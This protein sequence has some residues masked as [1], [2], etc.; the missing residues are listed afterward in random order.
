MTSPSNN[1]ATDPESELTK[2]TFSLTRC[3]GLVLVVASLALAGCDDGGDSSSDDI[4]IGEEGEVGEEG[5]R[6]GIVGD[7][8]D[9]GDVGDEGPVAGGP[10]DTG[11]VGDQGPIV[12]GP[13]DTGDVGDQGPVV[14][15]PG[16]TGDVGDQGPIVG[17]PG[18]TGDVG[19]QGP[20]VGGPGDTGDVGDEGP[21]GG[22][23]C[24]GD[25]C[26]D[27]QPPSLR[28]SVSSTSLEHYQELQ[29]E[30]DA[31]DP[32]GAIKAVRFML[33][34]YELQTLT[35][36]PYTLS[37]VPPVGEQVFSAVA[38]DNDGAASDE[39]IV[40][41]SV[42]PLVWTAESG[43]NSVRSLNVNTQHPYLFVDSELITQILSAGKAD[44]RS[45]LNSLMS[46]Y[47]TPSGSDTYAWVE[48]KVINF[49]SMDQFI[50]ASMYYGMEANFNPSDNAKNHAH[51]FALALLEYPAIWGN[52]GP[53]R[54]RL[55]ALGA[56]Y[57]WAYDELS[58]S[59]RRLLRAA[60]LEQADYVDEKWSY[61][62]SPAYSGGHSRKA[63][64]TA[65]AA[66]LAIFHDISQD[67]SDM[68]SRY[69]ELLA[70]VVNN[71]E[72]GYNPFLAWTSRNGGSEKAYSYSTSYG[73]LDVNLMWEYATNE[74]SWLTEVDADQFYRYLYGIRNLNG[75][76]AY[77]SGGYYNFPYHGDSWGTDY[78]RQFQ[79]FPMLV[80]STFFDNGYAQWLYDSLSQTNFYWHILYA[81]PSPISP[82]NPS[83]L[84]LSRHFYNSGQVV[85][86]DS[87]DPAKNTLTI[88]KST[89]FNSINHHH[90]DSNAFT[91]Y[92]KGPLAI[93]SGG[94]NIMGA[95]ASKHWWNYYTRSIA[96][97]TILVY[98]KTEDFRSVPTHGQRSNDGG[99]RYRQWDI[100]PTLEDVKAGG[101]SH[102][103]GIV[104]YEEQGD[105]TYTMGDATEAYSSHKLALYQR[106][107][108]SLRNHSGSHPVVLVYDVVEST[109]ADYSKTYLL[110]SV[111]QPTKLSAA[112]TVRVTI[113]TGVDDEDIASL[114]QQTLL[115][116]DSQV[117]I[118]GGDGAEFLVYDDGSCA[119]N[120]NCT[121]DSH[122][123][124]EDRGTGNNTGNKLA[125]L[126][127]GEWRIEVTPSY[128]SI[129][130]RFLN[131]LT[132]A[133]GSS[134]SGQVD[135][136]YLA[137][138]ELD[139]AL[140]S[141]SDDQHTLVVFA[142]QQD[143]LN[144]SIG[145]DVVENQTYSDVLF[146][147]LRPH[148]RYQVTD[149]Y[150]TL[151]IKQDS[152]GRFYSSSQG[153]LY[154]SQLDVLDS[155]Q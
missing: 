29:I 155:D 141:A 129:E 78:S 62:S 123:Y 31:S 121:P 71:F 70:I 101:A 61:F 107:L 79:G 126:E 23:G 19:D 81:D 103:T 110:H 90:L 86:R 151:A 25:D 7:Q 3:C 51:A 35:Q 20:I 11:D 45:R 56:I 145:L 66:L 93:D 146:I 58:S 60:I 142:K 87:W 89:S 120:S 54:G 140:I 65:L 109:D 77:N 136:L 55:F 16:D 154:L 138:S 116:L 119:G 18:D 9:T 6:G 53:P 4:I 144:S 76:S 46:S 98:D 118:V 85:I 137:G 99:Q 12:G 80:A 112:N 111:N 33:D 2:H 74:S 97:N 153:T 96:H 32:D 63:N 95:Y 49:T 150:G 48:N 57:D 84:P 125:L 10:G 68:Q 128:N 1:N 8:G 113:D 152:Q 135:A 5:D 106:H 130:D 72:S 100:Y 43:P 92:Y 91:I 104:Y 83:S 139:A 38:V 102:I 34:G 41:V 59:E 26:D 149:S 133:D 132:I 88:F 15:G 52:D 47:Y 69:Y 13:G 27:N 40:T 114:Y 134:S 148:T 147:G 42:A 39:D 22:D 36:A 75:W 37:Y 124:V 24:V 131:V 117:A 105:Y 115:P 21:I 94:Y 67:S 64:I 127:A 143:D 30:A 14:G 44:D 73:S 28:L 122:N 82:V 50:D 17:G 108:V